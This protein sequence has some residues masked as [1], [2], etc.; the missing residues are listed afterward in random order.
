[1]SEHFTYKKLLD[2]VAARA[3]LAGGAALALAAC[4]PD[5]SLDA[6]G[7]S[8]DVT[9][10]EQGVAGAATVTLSDDAVVYE[11][12]PTTNHGATGTDLD[13]DG[14]AGA[15]VRS[16][17]KFT[18]SGIP[19]GASVYSALLKLTCDDS[20][21]NGPGIRLAS[22]SWS[23]DTVTWNSMP[24][25]AST[26]DTDNLGE[27][28]IPASGT[29]KLVL[30]LLPAVTGNGT[31]SFQL[32]QNGTNGLSCYSK[33]HPTASYR[34]VVQVHYS[35]GPSV[36]GAS[37]T[38]KLS[39]VCTGTTACAP[40]AMTSTET[41]STW[42]GYMTPV[43][44]PKTL[45]D[46]I[47]A[48]LGE[49]TGAAAPIPA[50]SLVNWVKGMLWD[51]VERS[52]TISST[53]RWQAQGLA[54]PGEL[55][56]VANI[57]LVGWY[58]RYALSSATSNDSLGASITIAN[59][60]T[61]QYRRILLVEPTG[62]G[63]YKKIVAH[64]GGLARFGNY[65]FVED[66][67]DDEAGIAR[68]QTRVFDLTKLYQVS[69]TD[70]AGV[71]GKNAAGAYCAGNLKYILPQVN[72]YRWPLTN[73]SN[74]HKP[75][76]HL[77]YSEDRTQLTD[78]FVIAEYGDTANTKTT[79]DCNWDPNST[80]TEKNC[81]IARFEVGANGK[82]VL[83][84]SNQAVARKVYKMGTNVVQGL[85][86]LCKGPVSGGDCDTY[87]LNSGGRLTR[88]NLSSASASWSSAASTWT[89]GNEGFQLDTSGSQPLF[90]NDTE[91]AQTNGVGRGIFGVSANFY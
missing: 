14:N 39:A 33:E 38:E 2:T 55:S 67:G 1:M 7:E 69:T 65:L 19:A 72:T 57:V 90:W 87:L 16:F 41:W 61:Y 17:I 64:S 70:C 3:W 56:S 51:T 45:N 13:T 53:N 21:D 12:S 32:A 62:S 8:Q 52:A 5:A 76:R 4:G 11:A 50:S 79:D 18:V 89:T 63:T 71:I 22:D 80:L 46:L 86:A 48:D 43:G 73:L 59:T 30:N 36:T 88:T 54:L 68:Q 66:D 82:L 81:R 34:P 40:Y 84:A 28:L 47:T 85:S 75:M 25:E 78:A 15:R 74:G 77:E 23:E 6:A 37:G 10:V 83:N 35:D 60:S 24:G 44:T 42:A 27:V 20:T 91:K 9:S 49:R 58:D 29:V 26:T 31:F